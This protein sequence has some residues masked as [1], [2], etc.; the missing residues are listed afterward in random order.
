MLISIG[1]VVHNFL[2]SIF[3]L[4]KGPVK[5]VIVVTEYAEF[6][7]SEVFQV[8]TDFRVP[9][10]AKV[11]IAVISITFFTDMCFYTHLTILAI[12]SLKK[13]ADGIHGRLFYMKTRGSM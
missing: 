8:T 3:T 12:T 9:E 7:I 4:A 2:K 10:H 13:L 5:L 1:K 11:I 6:A